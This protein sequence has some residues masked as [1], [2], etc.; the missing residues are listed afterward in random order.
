MKLITELT[1]SVECLV[2]T[3]DTGK[4]HFISGIFMQA[5][6]KNRNGRVYPR[7]VLENQVNA[8]QDKIKRKTA[9]S[10]LNHPNGP[11]IDLGRVS[12]LITEPKFDG[13]NVVGKAKVLST[14]CGQI[15]KNWIED[16]VQFGVSSRGLGSVTPNR[17]GINEVQND[18]QLAAID[19]VADPSGPD[20]WISGIMENTEW[21]PD[22]IGGWRAIEAAE[23][24]QKEINEAVRSHELAV[25]KVALFERYLNRIS[26]IL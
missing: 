22:G 8:Y 19:V 21:I 10:E 15:V 17:Q 3:T 20:C 23:Q 1:E 6:I 7:S 12:H 24:S 11:Q 2:E 14:P 25:K 4:N 9:L 13:D 26:R 16:G 5:N 18:V